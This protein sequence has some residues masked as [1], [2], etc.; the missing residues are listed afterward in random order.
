MP[1][2]PYLSV[3]IPAYNEERR[4]GATLARIVEYLERRSLDFEVLVVDDGSLDGTVKVVDVYRE[5]STTSLRH[6]RNLGKGAAVRTGLAAS[7]GEWVLITDADLSA[8]IDDLPRLESLTEHYDLVLGSRA[9]AESDVSVHQPLPRELMGRTFNLI[10]RG[11]GLVTF[12]DTQCGFKLIRGEAARALASDLTIN[13]F[14][15]DVELV[16]LARRSQLQ[17]I[18]VG[19]RWE[20]SADSRVRVF[21]DSLNM[22]WDVIKIRFRR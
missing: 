4:I 20:N 19:V 3:V 10:L 9:L 6:P 21:S 7:R 14:A 2:T 13:G 16:W 15:Y 12:R 18:E 22:L 8:P 11:L 1:L 17:V 5:H